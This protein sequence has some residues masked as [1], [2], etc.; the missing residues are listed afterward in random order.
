MSNELKFRAMGI[1]ADRNGD[2]RL[3]NTITECRS[4]KAGS[5]LSFGIDE[6]TGHLLRNQM[7]GIRNTH[8]AVCMII[9]A[10]ELSEIEKMLQTAPAP[11][12]GK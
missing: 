5:I 12:T 11:V 4:V 3:S 1:L 8:I 10:A 6:S 7:L 2:I 9:N